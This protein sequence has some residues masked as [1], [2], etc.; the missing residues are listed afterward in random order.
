MALETA[1]SICFSFC[2]SSISN[3]VVHRY[4]STLV[5]LA[6]FFHIA[7]N[8]VIRPPCDLT[9]VLDA[10]RSR[11]S[12]G[13]GYEADIVA[14]TVAGALLG[15]RA[16]CWTSAVVLSIGGDDCG[17]FA[18]VVDLLGLIPFGG[19]V[20]GTSLQ[21]DG[22]PLDHNPTT[23]HPT[24]PSKWHPRHIIRTSMRPPNPPPPTSTKE[25]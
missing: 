10:T 23:P 8:A 16:T 20:A 14:A 13:I 11:L 3:L 18:L 25:H 17:V 9:G 4:S 7:Y 6:P 2:T 1:L 21:R 5:S 24:T 15:P 22:V 19:D 12:K